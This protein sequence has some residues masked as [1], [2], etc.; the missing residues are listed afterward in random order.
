MTSPFPPRRGH[1]DDTDLMTT[2]EVA[3]LLQT[4]KDAVRRLV[5]KGE[6]ATYC[7]TLGGHRRYRRSAAMALLTKRLAAPRAVSLSDP[8]PGGPLAGSSPDMAE[9]AS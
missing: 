7:R 4:N 2:G 1:S 6:L 3:R 8:A 9:A 5:E